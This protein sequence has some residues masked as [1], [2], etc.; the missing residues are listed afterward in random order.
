MNLDDILFSI[1]DW[2]NL[3]NP[4]GES[5]INNYFSEGN[6]FLFDPEDFDTSKSDFLHVYFGVA[7]EKIKVFLIAS[8]EDTYS[9]YDTAE[10]I[11]PYISIASL[12]KSI[13][14]SENLGGEIPA[15][16]A[17]ARIQSWEN[18]HT[19]WLAAQALTADNIFQA[20][21]IPS[22]DIENGHKLRIYLGLK[23][24]PDG[25]NDLADLVVFDEDENGQLQ[26][27]SRFFDMAR[28]VPPF[29]A[30]GVLKESNFYLLERALEI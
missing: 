30:V 22:A 13:L 19:T 27:I 7:D 17:I 3:R 26:A 4:Q 11:M 2:N 12:K 10:G 23:S 5:L 15:P 21:A 6:S 24:N 14:L 28:P 16:E 9:Q 18:N 25:G 29:G 8:D 1:R 20:F